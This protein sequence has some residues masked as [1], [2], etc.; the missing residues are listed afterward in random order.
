MSDPAAALD[1]LRA[2]AHEGLTY[3]DNPYDRGRYERLA[4][5]RCRLLRGS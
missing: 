2:I 3:A 1:Q 5:R 4:A